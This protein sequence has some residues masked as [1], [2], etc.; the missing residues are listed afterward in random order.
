MAIRSRSTGRLSPLMRGLPAKGNSISRRLRKA[1][2][3][4]ISES[5]QLSKED[6][7][8]STSKGYVR[9]PPKKGG[10]RSCGSR[11]YRVKSK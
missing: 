7:E 1:T 2:I 4:P 10:C 3:S 9:T 5:G 6:K 11:R 8:K